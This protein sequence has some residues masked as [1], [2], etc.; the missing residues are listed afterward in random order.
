MNR[1][2]PLLMLL[3]ALPALA[4]DAEAGKKAFDASCARCHS[5][6]TAR[7]QRQAASSTEDLAL[8]LSTHSGA[9]LRQWVSDP[10]KLKPQTRCDPRQLKSQDMGDLISY[11]R[12][13]QA[14]ATP[15]PAP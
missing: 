12:G 14:A 7:A 13:A 15:A 9:E 3:L 1:F 4:T 11:L 2:L 5:A 8:W 10:W 6:G